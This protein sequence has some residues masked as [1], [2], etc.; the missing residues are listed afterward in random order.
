MVL[1]PRSKAVIKERTAKRKNRRAESMSRRKRNTRGTP[2]AHSDSY[3]TSGT[4]N[5]QRS[6]RGKCHVTW[7]RR[8]ERPP[9]VMRRQCSKRKT[10]TSLMC[11]PSVSMCTTTRTPRRRR[12]ATTSS[13]CSAVSNG[14]RGPMNAPAATALCDSRT[15][16]SWPILGGQTRHRSALLPMTSSSSKG[17]EI[18]LIVTRQ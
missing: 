17:E 8:G 6:S 14:S 3:Q 18:I 11:A 13:I 16:S 15:S 7:R 10:K 1:V 2:P 4:Q 12:S 9:E 5:T